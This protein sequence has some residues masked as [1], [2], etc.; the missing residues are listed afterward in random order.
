M[1]IAGIVN[2]FRLKV[3]LLQTIELVDVEIGARFQPEPRSD[4]SIMDS[5]YS[6]RVIRRT[7]EASRRIRDVP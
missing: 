3:P 7:E 4:G 5:H 1:R 6:F 2:H